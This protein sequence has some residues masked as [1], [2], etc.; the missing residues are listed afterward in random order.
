MPELY[1]IGK[2]IFGDITVKTIDKL[3]K[4]KEFEEKY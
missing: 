4:G 2:A 3:K 1:I